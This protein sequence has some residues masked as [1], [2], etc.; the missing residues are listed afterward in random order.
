MHLK[1]YT[2]YSLR[3]LIYLGLHP[4]RLVTI[5]EIAVA[6]GISRNHLMKVAKDLVNEGFVVSVKGKAGGLRLAR[7]AEAINIGHVIRRME[8]D[9]NLVECHGSQNSCCILPACGLKP[10]LHKAAEAFLKALEPYSLEDVLTDRPIL[11]QLILNKS[12]P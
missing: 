1:R 6:F 5:G 9:F 10:A 11:S 2:D 8:E 12:H 7:P 3:V 4:D